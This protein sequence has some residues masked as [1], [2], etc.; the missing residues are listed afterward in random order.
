M[1][2]SSSRKQQYNWT[3]ERK[4]LCSGRQHSPC[5]WRKGKYP[6]LA[7]HP[8][9]PLS[10]PYFPPGHFQTLVQRGAGQVESY[11]LSRWGRQSSELGAAEW[12]W[13]MWEDAHRGNPLEPWPLSAGGCRVSHH[14]AWRGLCSGAEGWVGRP[15]LTMLENIGV[16]ALS[17]QR[18]HPEND[19]YSSE[20]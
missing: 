4:Q 15:R 19:K 20:T 16:W 11:N 7:Q 9:R 8:I 6:K 14:E 10:S 18:K 2:L 3:R 1:G 12:G 17:E 5:S 13:N